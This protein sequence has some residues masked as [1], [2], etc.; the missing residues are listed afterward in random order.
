MDLLER[1][2]AM[3]SFYDPLVTEI[4]TT[5][6]YPGLAGRK[7]IKLLAPALTKFDLILVCTDHDEIDYRFLLER[8]QL[9]MDTRNVL[10]RNNLIDPKVIKA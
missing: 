7:S 9:V 6:E 10:A 1:R 8:A 4:P 5:R 3:V 2:G